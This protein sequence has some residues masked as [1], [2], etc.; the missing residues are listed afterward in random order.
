MNIKQD[1]IIDLLPLYFDGNASDETQ[2]LIEM[3]FEQHPT[4]AK[5]MKQMHEQIKNNIEE[6]IADSIQVNISPEQKL[7]TL[8]RTKVLLRVRATLFL[9][10]IL[11]LILPILFMVFV[12][13]S[14]AAEWAK[15]V[16]TGILIVIMPATWVG[17]AYIRYR[18][19]HSGDW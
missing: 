13:E 3:Y 10:G 16:V 11:S 17:Y 12:K 2:K 1:V 7:K 14:N 4:F 15:Y 5:S 18:M 8:Q 19:R 6:K 9:T